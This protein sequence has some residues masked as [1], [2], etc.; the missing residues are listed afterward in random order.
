MQNAERYLLE[1]D[2]IVKN[3][4]TIV[5]HLGDLYFKTG[6]F[7]KAESFWMR[8]VSI[9]TEEESVQKVRRKLEMLQERLRKQ[10]PG[11]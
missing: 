2:Q 5:D 4:P 1:A 3:D 8:S 6:D 11:K 9:G 10:K 7:Q